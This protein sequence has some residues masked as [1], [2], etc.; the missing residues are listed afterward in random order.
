ML[1]PS[2]LQEEGITV[3]PGRGTELRSVVALHIKVVAYLS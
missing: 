2:L 1:P 3:C